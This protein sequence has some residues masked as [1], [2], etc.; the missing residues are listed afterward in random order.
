MLNAVDYL[1]KYSDLIT[2][3]DAIMTLQ[4]VGRLLFEARKKKQRLFFTGNGASSSISS[5]AA[6]DFTKQGKL[7][8]FSFTD[9]ALVSA[10]S[11]DYG[12]ENAQT[13]IFKSYREEGDILVLVSTS[14]NS[15]NVVNLARFGRLN[16]HQVV[17]LTGKDPNNL[18]RTES[19][20]SLWVNSHAYNMVENVHMIWLG[21]LID[22]LVGS[23]VYAVS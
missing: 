3:N 17:S 6:L 20:Y 14:G 21:Y 10:Y 11:N 1:S 4:N 7:T 5:H 19:D 15:L 13:E 23:E 18:L 12:F 8:A 22:C 2:N 16:G 9:P